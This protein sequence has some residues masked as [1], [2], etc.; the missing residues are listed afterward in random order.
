[1][2]IKNLG[3][4]AVS[5]FLVSVLAVSLFV[6]PAFAADRSGNINYYSNQG[7]LRDDAFVTLPLS[8]V[9]ASGW[10]ENQLLLQ[11]N[12]LT[13]HMHLF[14]EYNA[15]TSRWLGAGS[16]EA[17]ERGPYY[18]RGLV[19]LA[20]ELED[21][22]LMDEAMLWINAMINSQ[23][24]SGTYAGGF[25]PR[26][27]SG[28]PNLIGD[29]W[30][31]MP[32]LVAM[33]DYY[34]YT[35]Y[36]GIP[37]NRVMSF[38]E[39]YFRFQETYCTS[40]SNWAN[41]RGADNIDSILWFYNRLY[42]PANPNAA[43]WLLTLANRLK[44]YTDDWITRYNNETV[45][46]H[47]V[48]TSQGLK[49]PAVWYQYTG[50]LTDRNAA[51]NGIFNWSIDHGR[52]DGLPNSDEGARDNRAT[53]GTETCG[54]VENLLSMEI[55]ERVLGEAWIG[56]YIERIAYN[57]LPAAMTPDGTGH[58]YYVLQNQVLATLGHHEFDNDHGDSSAFSAPNGYDCCFSNYHMGWPKF[59]Q[60]MWM[61]T[62]DNG[63]AITAY[64]PNSV[65]AKVAD[66]K[67]AKFAQETDYP[68]KDTV[69][70]SY[71][72]D[73]AS[74]ELKLRIP[75][76]AVNPVV[77]VNG[78]AMQGIVCGEYYTIDRAW[79]YGDVVK[80]TFPSEIKASTW[81][82]NSVG[83]EKG[84]LIYG[85]KIDEQW[86]RHDG[87]SGNDL[88]EL[89]T[90]HKPDF[91]LRE[92]YAASDWNYGLVIDYDN[93]ASG[94][95]VE[96]AQQVALQPFSLD[97]APVTLKATGQIVPNW[98]LD[99]NLVG[100]QPFV[101]PYD[102]ALT[103]PVELIPYGSGRLRISQ[104]PRIG[105]PS[106][107]VVRTD[108]YTVNVNGTL[109][110]EFRNVVVPTAS[111]FTLT[112]TG[113]GSGS[114]V[115][116]GRYTTSIS[117]TSGTATVSNLR[118]VITASGFRFAEGQFNNLRFTSG[119]TVE[120]IKIDPV[121][122]TYTDL[123]VSGATRSTSHMRFTTNLSLQETPFSVF[124]GTE[125]GVYDMEVWGF[126]SSTA[127]V[128]GIDPEKTYYAKVAAVINGVYKESQEYVFPGIDSGDDN[129][130]K[131]NPNAIPGVYTGFN[132]LNYM[133]Q[134]W[135]F[136]DPNN[137]I[138]FTASDPPN[139]RF[140]RNTNMKAVL[141][142]PGSSQWMDYVAEATITLDDLDR[143]NCGLMLRTTGQQNGAD[144]YNGYF[145]GIGRVASS[146]N[147]P[148][149]MIGYADGGW[150]D[151]K[152]VAWPSIAAGR[153]YTIKVVAYGYR[154]AVYVNDEFVTTFEDT[155]FGNGTIGLRAYDEGFTAHNVTVRPITEDDLVVFI[156]LE[157][158]GL[159]PNVSPDAVYSGFGTVS[160]FSSAWQSYGN[161]GSISVVDN[162]GKAQ[163]NIAANTNV[164]T[165][166]TISLDT[167]VNPLTWTDYVAEAR[168]SVDSATNNNCGL[169]VRATNIGSGAD[170]YQGY[171][172]GIGQVADVSGTGVIIG[173]ADGSSWRTVKYVPWDIRAGVEYTL[174]TVTYGNKLAVFVDGVFA[175]SADNLIYSAGTI[176]LRSYN[177]AFKV[178]DVKVSNV[179]KEDLAA[180]DF[181]GSPSF[182][183]DFS[184]VTTS[185]N[186]WTRLGTS[187]T[188]NI[189]FTGGLIRFASNTNVKAV[190]GQT[191]WTNYVYEVDVKRTVTGTAGDS[192]MIFR[193]TNAAAGTD[194]YYGYYFG[195][196][197]TDFV[198]GRARNNW[199]EIT[200]RASDLVKPRNQ[201]NHLKVVANGSE[202]YFYLNGAL[203]HSMTDTNYG[204]GQIGLRSYNAAVDYDN[205]S[206][207]AVSSQDLIEIKTNTAKIADINNVFAVTS[208]N[209][210]EM[211]FPKVPGALTYKVAFG[212]Q[213]GVYTHEFVDAGT[214]NYKSGIT[215]AEKTAVMAPV[216]GTYY[217]R[218][219][220]VNGTSIVAASQE[221]EV[222]TG[223]EESAAYDLGKLD[224]ALTAAQ[225]INTSGY[226]ETS[227][228]RLERAI[229]LALAVKA[230]PQAGQMD[231]GVA[232]QLLMCGAK[233]DSPDFD[234][235]VY[236]PYIVIYQETGNI[237]RPEYYV[238]NT[239]G[240][241][242]VDILM[243]LAIYDSS[244]KMTA[245]YQDSA[246]AAAGDASCFTGLSGPIPAGGSAKAFM[247]DPGSYVPLCEAAST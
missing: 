166:L 194:N 204:N 206:V 145:V 221:F 108:S 125:S 132:T 116:N 138:S 207:R 96:E 42:D 184:N 87:T 212:T 91:P 31:G 131:P 3:K 6:S 24:T 48:N 117:L 105:A 134:D 201:Y 126:N 13:G 149:V 225:V 92:V 109:Y 58:T 146:V 10:L 64:G 94:F 214:N 135:R 169:M 202:L 113:S 220:G 19:A 12:G 36:K 82:N 83:I 242:D 46:Y 79:K 150:H 74:F 67:T 30:P 151:I 11:K 61:A 101:T 141:E 75:V 224:E 156:Q 165:A 223:Y 215:K 120:S 127:T 1:M 222:V 167:S 236:R 16:G 49:L 181:E 247:W 39:N 199:T 148:G 26:N 205:V 147:G 73:D 185:T 124:Y 77:T 59:V 98:K 233:A 21:P 76:W 186:Q 238:V 162:G 55:T 180:F 4:K 57:A 163:V 179:K 173:Y 227:L 197:A 122:R 18:M 22:V 118:N 142:T 86:R 172:A 7:A 211:K 99:G 63:L 27:T 187:P 45:R 97:G 231:I 190:A 175:A 119:L 110:T 107:S 239:A 89:Q 115:V 84:A 168:L 159:T 203:V 50:S 129:D 35:V 112:V 88:R 188:T 218:L 66:G 80:I 153:Q 33:R 213:P 102:E 28:R 130:L 90:A 54:I 209:I 52:I 140:N 5:F 152:P 51:R 192:G 243:Y 17:W 200:R 178:Y 232:R 15:T 29:W 143:N 154:F 170:A 111:N 103:A 41:N 139:I 241:M 144:G 191:S 196:T 128:T 68:F 230:D 71:G 216:A 23:L 176:G 174:K 38:L 217:V 100:P 246:T 226:T 56:D 121:T 114:M 219:Y 72:G 183:D 104:F 70:L 69:N 193:V 37:D 229:A 25:G 44:G 106:D 2:K 157:S 189:T 245:L 93:P 164:K 60:T 161:T 95:E 228:D 43:Q 237:A 210:I 158:G 20:F 14:N 62:R 136:Y 198:I 234:Y 40:L 182:S 137:V 155:R 85:L 177:E 78:K 133:Q 244:G 123:V 65:T 34:D 47:V 53:R 208:G 160:E 195:I 240:Q 235:S 9:K 81:Y 32:I 8:A 171:F